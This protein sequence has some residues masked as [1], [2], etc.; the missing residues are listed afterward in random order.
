M[1]G[2]GD[3]YSIE[4]EL[5]MVVHSSASIINLCPGFL[6][7]KLQILKLGVARKNYKPVYI[8]RQRGYHGADSLLEGVRIMAEI[9]YSGK[10]SG[11]ARS[12]LIRTI[13]SDFEEGRLN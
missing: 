13:D 9:E 12:K 6:E 5:D 2:N 7:N 11:P 4:T 10:N 1:N 8:L 3:N